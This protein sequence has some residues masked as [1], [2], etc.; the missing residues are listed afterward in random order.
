[1]WRE[2]GVE[3]IKAALGEGRH[4]AALLTYQV[5]DFFIMSDDYPTY[6]AYLESGQ[7]F[8]P[9]YVLGEPRGPYAQA[10]RRATQLEIDK[11]FEFHVIE[12]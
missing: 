7:Q 4:I 8:A 2:H 6:Y 3:R 12:A 11:Q 9:C 10:V 1:M 5:G